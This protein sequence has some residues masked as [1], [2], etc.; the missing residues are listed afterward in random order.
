MESF[1]QLF[2]TSLLSVRFK[3]LLDKD[4]KSFGLDFKT[5]IMITMMVSF[6]TMIKAVYNYHVRHR[7]SLRP[8]F[9][10]STIVLVFCWAL[11]I[12]SKVVIYVICFINTPALIFIP[13]VLRI[14]VSFIIFECLDN[15][16][17]MKEVHEKF[18]YLLVSF[19]APISMASKQLK[20]TKK[21]YILNFI[22]YCAECFCLLF[23]CLIMRYFYHNKLYC[24]YF[25]KLAQKFNSSFDNLLILLFGL[26]LFVSCFCSFLLWFSNKSFHPKNRL[27]STKSRNKDSIEM[28]H[29]ENCNNLCFT[30]ESDSSGS[31]QNLS[32]ETAF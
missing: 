17:K 25:G 30:Q 8:M 18:I 32:Q 4:Y 13:I 22:L 29:H 28:P 19:L 24:S 26:V 21:L 7:S 12:V 23:F 27:M 31:G 14:F 10:L 2:V 16:F 1:G 9:S 15:D 6:S 11:L 3:W 5:Y 20:S